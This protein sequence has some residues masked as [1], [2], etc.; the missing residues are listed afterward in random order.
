MFG[1][2]IN[3]KDSIQDS[4]SLELK[5]IYNMNIFSQTTEEIVQIV[6]EIKK[7]Y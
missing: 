3:I 7:Y 2:I 6:G 5:K 1:K 4:L